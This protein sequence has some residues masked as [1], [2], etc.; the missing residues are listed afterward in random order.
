M[1]ALLGFIWLMVWAASCFAQQTPRD[2]KVRHDKKIVSAD[3][4]WIYNDPTKAAAQAKAEN[5]P[6]LLVFRCIPCEACSKFDEQL[7]QRD[8]RVASLM[9]QFICVRV[10]QANGMDLSRFQFDYDMSLAVFFL[11]AD[12]TILGRYATRTGRDNEDQD[13]DIEG[14]ARAM[15][16]TLELTNYYAQIKP[17]LAG[18][19]AQPVAIATPEQF[20]TLKSK[21]TDKLD[22]EGAVAKSCIHCH[23]IREAERAEELAK[24]GKLDERL[25]YPYPAPRVVGLVFDPKQCATLLDVTPNTPASRAGL[26]A[27][28]ALR[29]L[30]GQPLVSIADVQWVL[31]QAGNSDAIS[32]SYEREGKLAKTL[33]E[34]PKDW[35]RASDI[36]W[37]A[38]TWDLRR[39]AFGG[40]VLEKLA[41]EDRE[42]LKLP[43]EQMALLVKHV[44]Q[45]GDHARAKQAGFLKGDIVIAWDEQRQ[46]HNETQLLEEILNA[47]PSSK[48]QVEIMRGEKRLTL[49]L[50]PAK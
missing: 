12:G 15:E 44:G 7:V 14:F 34:L 3:E 8:P 29:H 23:N 28:D 5:K 39:I 49:Q 22:Y 38:T 41:A 4:R 6:I 50:A 33:L 31:H 42:K 11:H 45:Y 32:V 37:R 36:S 19:Q 35:R 16:Q 18:K 10:P 25:L 48:T 26:K 2:E 27:G 30:N 40:M 47:K 1:K 43:P 21:F 46:P 20:P 13:M 17:S 24:T 9:D